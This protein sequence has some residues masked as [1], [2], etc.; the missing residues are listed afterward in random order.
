MSHFDH[1]T[2]AL[3]FASKP[4]CCTCVNQAYVTSKLKHLQSVLAHKLKAGL[5]SSAASALICAG[6][7]DPW[8]PVAGGKQLGEAASVEEFIVLPGA[9]QPLVVYR[10][11]PRV[12][13]QS[14]FLHAPSMFAEACTQEICSFVHSRCSLPDVSERL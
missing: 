7:K 5:S 2:P 8:E 1:L 13:K 4:A 3:P 10:D 6:E 14:L 9:M 12:A 11:L